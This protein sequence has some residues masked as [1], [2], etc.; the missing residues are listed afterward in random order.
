VARCGYHP[1]F[2]YLAL[3][4]QLAYHLG[5]ATIT[6]QRR[7]HARDAVL[8]LVR[9]RPG[10]TIREIVDLLSRVDAEHVILLGLRDA[11]LAVAP[12]ESPPDP[13][14]EELWGPE[15]TEEDLAEA[16]QVGRAAVRDALGAALHGALTRDQA[17]DRIGVT[18]QAVSE[19]RKAGK[20]LGLRRGREW[21]F[22]AWQFADDGTVPGLELLI[23]GWS[24]TPLALST[25]A[26]RPSVDLEGRTPAQT[27]TR[28]H[29][30][31]RVSELAHAL[32]D[33]AW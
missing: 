7:A 31:D 18:P 4:A 10:I 14:D 26:T 22:P 25:W 30:P 13:L 19:R 28:R 27:L 21:R 16:R 23:A 5:V 32:G 3:F 33:A 15:P 20:L 8:E 11:D 2:A 24:G 1:Q 29:G 9:D 12:V 17:A 6:K